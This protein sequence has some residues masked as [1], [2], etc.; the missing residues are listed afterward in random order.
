M[1]IPGWGLRAAAGEPPRTVTQRDI[2]VVGQEEPRLAINAGGHTAA[3]H[4]L[5]F[6]PDS[7]RLCSAGLDKV[8]QVWNL[9]ATTRDLRGAYLRERTIRWQIA[10]GLRGSIFA[11]ACAPSDGLL[12]LGGYGA[13]GSLGEILLV[14]PIQGTLAKVLNQHRQTV[15][16]LCFSRDGAWLASMDSD[17]RAILWRR[18]DW[19]GSALY[20]TD[21]ETYGA[22]QAR[23]IQ[24]QP[25]LR[26]I[27]ILGDRYVVLPVFVGREADGRLRWQLQQ[28]SLADRTKVRTYPTIH[29]G[30][31]TALAAAADGSR[32]ASADLAGNLYLWDLSSD[33][34]R[35]ERLPVDRTVGALS[36]SPDGRILAVGTAVGGSPPRAQLQVWDVPSRVVRS[37]VYLVDHSQAVAISPDGR[38]LAYVG[39][40]DNQVF[41]Q[42][43]AASQPPVE[44]R[45]QG[46]R[47]MKV[48][49]AAEDPPY[50]IAF[51]T[52]VH[53]RGFNDYGDLQES[54]DPEKLQ[55]G[56]GPIDA[57][58]WI[59][60][61]RWAGDWTARWQPGGLQ[62]YRGG[63]AQGKVALD[64]NLDEG[65][66]RSYCWIPDRE[67]KPFAI[68]VG[69][70]RQNS[71]YVCR[72]VER[73]I[74]PILRHFRGHN[75]YVTSVGVSRD[76]RYLVSGSA[77]NTISIWSLAGYERGAEIDGRWGVRL[78]V[79]DRPRPG[80]A[81]PGGV[82][83]AGGTLLVV[84]AIDPAGPMYRKG[85]RQG[86][87]ITQIRWFD[88]PVKRTLRED[89]VP[90]TIEESLRRMPWGTQVEIHYARNGAKQPGFLLV[91][92]W[93]PVASLLV[94]DTGEWAFWTPE[95]YYDASVNGD[96]LF[97]WQ[98]N[99]GLQV[100]P[101]Y[102][103]AD[104]FR[105]R[106]EQPRVMERLLPAGS[107][108]EAFRQAAFQPRVE[109]HE[110]LPR[111]IA[112]TP[113]LT[114]VEPLCDVEVRG[115][116]TR[117]L[118]RI[119]VPSNRQVT[120]M[121]V[122]DNG[123]VATQQR[124]VAERQLETS[125]ELTYEWKVP[126][127]ADD[128]HLIQL[129]VTTDEDATAISDLVIR[130]LQPRLPRLPRL[131]ILAAGINEYQ[132]KRIPTLNYSASDARAFLKTLQ[133][134]AQG[135]YTVASATLLTNDQVT[136]EGWEQS[137]RQ[138]KETLLREAVPDDLL[139]I[140][141]AGHGI[142]DLKTKQ[143]YFI[144]HQ[145]D[146]MNLK[147]GDWTGCISWKDFRILDDVP[148]RKLAILDTCHSGAIQEPRSR[149]L[150]EAVRA[151][152][153]DVVFTLTA[154]TGDQLAA[155]N[156]EWG[157][158]VFTKS[159]L[160]ALDGQ[161][162]TQGNRDGV[163]TL[164]EAARYV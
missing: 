17:G 154:T 25:K 29:E 105:A 121:R 119:R 3:V 59:A 133:Q 134:R 158:G 122:Y 109:P 161:A 110:A 100:L 43:L 140:F 56:E 124:L 141:L 65:S 4:A 23:L 62:L 83:A 116:T 10:R 113:R 106:L 91:P 144:G 147:R 47:V 118:A 155:E 46:R 146:L 123:V 15:C 42:S 70:D 51:G 162:D 89:A 39:G 127:P 27:L 74:C 41:V 55:P 19:K 24:K 77:D 126:L 88:D 67:G 93:Q 12:A 76:A 150:K 81:A 61:D 130:R 35:V 115:D 86:D 38:R 107:L 104:Q 73:G 114:I 108:E 11:L 135:L 60:P 63:A 21:Q 64:T 18:P 71:I 92:A 66:V 99:R 103:R 85:L 129:V 94:G 16:S 30:M 131:Y 50:R 36:F 117:V 20:G 96:T 31:V 34:P 101:D 37:R 54:F 44:L 6:T 156:S 53:E 58:R 137:L 95:G 128:R 159:L 9:D 152:E 163:V 132:D 160:E 22:D 72:L 120:R 90:A 157:H 97:G 142:A 14:D 148:C 87:V 68:A 48:A 102:Y 40:K 151:L 79:V 1:A 145:F 49:F 153:D 69:T 139:V 138:I 33:D 98:V 125:R 26:P 45:G 13:M 80:E 5:A 143:Y 78:E 84:R 164:N 32:L 28:V 136:P 52:D 2:V 8:V 75:D 82:G 112:A 111:Q 149:N 57:S 7:K